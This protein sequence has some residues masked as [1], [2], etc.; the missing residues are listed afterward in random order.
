MAPEK[1]QAHPSNWKHGLTSI[2]AVRAKARVLHEVYIAEVGNSSRWRKCLAD[3][4]AMPRPLSIHGKFFVAEPEPVG[5]GEAGDDA[6]ALAAFRLVRPNTWLHAGK[7]PEFVWRAL[8]EA[9]PRN[10]L[11]QF[12]ERHPERFRV[13]GGKDGNL[14]FQVLAFGGFPAAAIS[15]WR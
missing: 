3:P 8:Q 9:L 11:L 15:R 12:L 10:G 1:V 7:L 2:Q 4:A 13:A 6:R 5:T 14:R